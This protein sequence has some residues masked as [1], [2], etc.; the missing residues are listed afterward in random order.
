MRR[1]NICAQARKPE[2]HLH[3]TSTVEAG[4]HRSEENI[5]YRVLETADPIMDC[6]GTV[7]CSLCF[8]RKPDLEDP[9]LRTLFK[10]AQKITHEMAKFGLAE[11]LPILGFMHRKAWAEMLKGMDVFV[12]YVTEKIREHEYDGTIG[13][14]A[15]GLKKAIEEAE[16]N[17]LRAVGLEK[18]DILMGSSVGG[19]GAGE[20]G[21]PKKP[22]I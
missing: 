12:E 11:F 7:T 1:S 6:V 8:G 21:T 15:D 14:I 2:H 16:E 19:G 10:F 20:G 17:E 3:T 22:C 9:L 18:D 13:T 4:S 5:V